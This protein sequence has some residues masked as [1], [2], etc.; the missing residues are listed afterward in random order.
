[1]NSSLAKPDT[2][3]NF[4]VNRPPGAILVDR[5]QLQ[6][7]EQALGAA[8]VIEIAMLFAI[9]ARNSMAKI[10][11]AF[12]RGSFDEIVSTAHTTKSGAATLGCMVLADIFTD[13]EKQ[14]R[15]KET[16]KLDALI[17]CLQNLLEISLQQLMQ[18][19]ESL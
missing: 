8:S 18:R 1:M 11:D 16:A 13:M 5:Q 2:F 12:E 10:L 19:A 7:L 9:E 14:A 15:G 3:V 17:S 6:S 4:Q